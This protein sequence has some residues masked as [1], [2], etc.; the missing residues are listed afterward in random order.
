M[1]YLV[2]FTCALLATAA[3]AYAQDANPTFT[4]AH[5]EAIAGVDHVR[6][7][8]ESNTGFVYGGNVGYDIAA[9]KVVLGVEG[10]VT[11]AE[12]RRCANNVLA[13]GDELCEKAG[14]DLYAGGRIGAIL[15]GRTL[16]YAKVGYTN[17]RDVATYKLGG[18]SVETGDN[19]NGI[20]GGVGIETDINH[21]IVKLEYRYSNYEQG[22]ER[23]QGV[24]GLGYRF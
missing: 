2:P 6:S 12:N 21:F 15:G 23:H 7:S 20:R 11:S 3:P 17:A 22:V 13:A 5:V 18:T 4:G 10:E 16:L 24:I 9:G 1:R 8:P 19:L 14:R